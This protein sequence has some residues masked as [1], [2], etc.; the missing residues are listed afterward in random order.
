MM[1]GPDNPREIEDARPHAA[2]LIGKR[3]GDN[4]VRQI[5]N[6]M[7]LKLIFME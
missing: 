4:G 6:S 3:R 5:T 2:M 1:A 7:E